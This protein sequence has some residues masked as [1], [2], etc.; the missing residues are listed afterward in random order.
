MKGPSL[1][2]RVAYLLQFTRCRVCL[3]KA[4]LLAPNVEIY[5]PYR[6]RCGY[7]GERV[8]FGVAFAEASRPV[9]TQRRKRRRRRGRCSYDCS[10]CCWCYRELS[11]CRVGVHDP[12]TNRRRRGPPFVTVCGKGRGHAVSAGLEC[13]GREPNV[14]RSS[15][16][17]GKEAGGR[18]SFRVR[19]RNPA[20]KREVVTGRDLGISATARRS[21]TRREGR[22]FLAAAHVVGPF[23]T[24]NALK[25]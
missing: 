22:R 10:L 16:T 13:S 17:A 7:V 24:C 5:L 20:A 1:H 18:R 15:R 4:S 12:R 2:S 11:Q 19:T 3:L 8:L 14:Q 6:F 21:S 25:R 9:D 23:S